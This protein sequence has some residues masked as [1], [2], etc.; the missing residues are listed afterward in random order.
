MRFTHGGYLDPFVSLD[1]DSQF[2]SK[3]EDSSSP[4]RTF[5]PTRI[6]ESAGISRALLKGELRKVVTRLGFAVRENIDRL[7]YDAPTQ[8]FETR[9]TTESGLEW[10][11]WSRLAAEKERSVFKS[12]L[13]IFKAVATSE[14]DPVKRLYWPAVDVD[15]Q[16]TWSNKVTSFLSFDLFWQLRYDKQVDLRGQFKQ[17]TG[18]GLVWQLI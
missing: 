9:T 8:E 17:T 10:V 18:F 3:N 1:I 15:W 7:Y 13:R 5:T 14:N 2:F 12:E 4:T 16:N 6:S 11:T